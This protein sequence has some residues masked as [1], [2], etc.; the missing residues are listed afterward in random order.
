MSR[1]TRRARAI[2]GALVAVLTIGLGCTSRGSAPAAAIPSVSDP[3]DSTARLSRALATLFDD[4]RFEH[5]AWAVDVRSLTTGETLFT[6]HAQALMVPASNQKL[7]SAAVAAEHLGW[8]YRFTT[9][10]L[11]T[12][13]IDAHGTLN[14]D[15]VVVGDGDP[16]INPRHPERWRVFDDWAQALR[17]R[18]L[19]VVSGHL[20]G[21]DNTMAEPGW[22]DG[23]S[24]DDLAFGYGAPYGALQYHENQIEVLIGPGLEPGARAIVAT[25]PLGSGLLVDNRA[26]TTA[27]GSETRMRIARLP[28]TIH[29]LL[30]GEIALD[31]APITQLAAVDNPTRLY[32]SAFREALGRKGIVVA[33]SALDIDELRTP[34]DSSAV[35]ELV[36]DRS[37]PLADLIDVSLKWSRNGYAETLL[38]ALSGEKPAT[39]AQGLGVLIS[40]LRGWNVRDDEYLPRDGSGLSRYDYVSARMLTTV[41]AHLWSDA[42]HREAFRSSL[43]VAGVSGSLAERMKDTSATGRVWAK[44]G[45]LSNVRTLSGYVLTRD[46]EPLVFSIL[47]NHYR[48]PTTE[49]DDVTDRAIVT[50]SQFSRR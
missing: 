19:R 50:L 18:G 46:D 13:S 21:D 37:A 41:L 33:G 48:T 38:V 31:A 7:L 15:L 3:L 34:P 44:T 4:E 16:S 1:L 12:G 30:E 10:L 6:R 11:A 28:S 42:R 39:A 29:L 36:V 20:V 17:D 49:V 45:T 8:D 32:L 24:W 35:T 22:G 25:A 2:T 47:A 43:P 14:G 40:T 23:W 5:A 27:V 9:R 26:V